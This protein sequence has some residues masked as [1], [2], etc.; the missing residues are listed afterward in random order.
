MAAPV[1][2]R[3]ALKTDRARR[4][5]YEAAG[6]AIVDASEGGLEAIV[7]RVV[8]L[9]LDDQGRLDERAAARRPRPEARRLYDVPSAAAQLSVSA[10]KAWGLIKDGRLRAVKIDGR[11]LV[12]AT[13]LDRFAAHEVRAG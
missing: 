3:A 10:A 13:E 4:G 5:A 2:A 11:T 12:Q 7:A 9:V 6:A 8:Q 1:A